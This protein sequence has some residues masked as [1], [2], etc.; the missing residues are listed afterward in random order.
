M[1]DEKPTASENLR[2]LTESL[3][4][5]VALSMGLAVAY[6]AAARG[7]NVSGWWTWVPVVLLVACAFSSI[8]EL[9]HRV[10]EPNIDSRYGRVLNWVAII[11]FGAGIII[12]GLAIRLNP[13]INGNS[14]SRANTTG[15]HITGN[16]IQIG[17]DVTTRTKIKRDSSGNITDIEVN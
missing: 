14:G 6:L 4:L 2:T 11:C 12:A 15:I 3:K 1:T 10:Y 17:P 13:Q 9:N 7:S 16:E 5:Y 8:W